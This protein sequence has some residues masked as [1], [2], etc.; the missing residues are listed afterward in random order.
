[1]HSTPTATGPLRSDLV[2]PVV[3]A[4]QPPKS[5]PKTSQE[6]AAVDASG[7]LVT[8]VMVVHESLIGSSRAV[9]MR[10]RVG[11]TAVMMRGRVG[12]TAGDVR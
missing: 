8:M 5:T 9:I 11:T 2:I 6:A 12:A 4:A 3:H 7:V 1:M 10:R